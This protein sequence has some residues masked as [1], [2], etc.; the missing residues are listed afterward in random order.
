MMNPRSENGKG[1]GAARAQA[2]ARGGAVGQREIAR[3]RLE[4]RAG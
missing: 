1:Q 2:L 3:A 4:A